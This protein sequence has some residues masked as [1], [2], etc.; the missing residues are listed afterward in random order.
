M[1]ADLAAWDMSTVDRVGIHDPTVGLILAGLSDR[2]SLVV[3]NGEIVVR[4]S[5]CLV[6]D[7]E[8]VAEAARNA[9]PVS[10]I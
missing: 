3:I 6:V 4:D 8:V 2:A 9:I 5:Q 10:S 7:E 1:T